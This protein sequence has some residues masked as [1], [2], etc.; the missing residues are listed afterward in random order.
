[1]LEK[2]TGGESIRLWIEVAANGLFGE[3]QITMIG[4]TDPNRYFNLKTCELVVFND[5]AQSLYWDLEVLLGIA[6]EM[7]DTT[8]LSNDAL[9]IAN[10]I[11][12]TIIVGKPETLHSAKTLAQSFFEARRR[13]GD[14]VP[15]NIIAIGN[16]HID[17][18]W[19][20]PYDETKRKVARSWSTQCR[21]LEQFPQYTFAASQ[22]QQFEWVEQLYPQLF[23]K[24]QGLVKQ[25]KFIP[26]GGTWVEMD[27]NIPSG[28]S[29]CRQ[30]LY[31]QSYFKSKFGFYPK[32]F[33]LPDTFGYSSQLPQIIK[34]A[35][36]EYFFTQK[37]SWYKE[38]W[39][40]TF[41]KEQHQQISTH[42]FLLEGFGWYFSPNPLFAC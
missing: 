9:Y 42:L 21:F 12:N 29:F 26:I 15:H 28:E 8:Q 41:V 16:C 5:L 17:T 34:L 7:P 23:A 20:W 24:I 11:V 38:Y 31:G 39:A 10:Q 2:A 33:W 27:C 37:L 35:K 1:M 36:L 14:F 25:D 30:F 19:L 3:G 13:K 32:I 4:P 18:A 40:L 6:K 22:A